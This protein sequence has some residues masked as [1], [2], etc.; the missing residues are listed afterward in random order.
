MYTVMLLSSRT[1]G[2]SWYR[3]LRRSA[4][5]G[6]EVAVSYKIHSSS[7]LESRLYT[8]LPILALVYSSVGPDESF[9][10]ETCLH[11]SHVLVF[12]CCCCFQFAVV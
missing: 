6:G 7:V 11:A 9:L 12:P 4:Y 5:I 2:P 10:R 3:I 1:H 8:I